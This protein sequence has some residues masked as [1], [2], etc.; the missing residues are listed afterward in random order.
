[1][2]V[3]ILVVVGRQ[4]NLLEIVLAL[5]PGGGFANLLH[6]GHQQPNQDGDD[7]DHNQ[8]FDQRET[9]STIVPCH[10]SASTNMNK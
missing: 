8:Q 7:G 3:G 4:G 1:M 10:D 2:L 9:G 5:G 6:R